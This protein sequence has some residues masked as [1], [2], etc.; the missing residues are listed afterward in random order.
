MRG[1]KRWFAIESKSFEVSVEEARGKIRG[2]IVE[3]SRAKVWE[4]EGRKFK[5]ERRENGT[6]R[7]I[8]CYVIDVESKRFCLMV[9][10][11]KGIPGGWALFAE[12]LRDLGV[13][14]Q[15]EV[16]EKEASRGAEWK[17]R[18][19]FVASSWRESIKEQGEGIGQ[20]PCR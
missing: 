20:V 16:K 2:T 9:P 14:T 19:C 3:R 12:K 1:G 18:R 11:G 10:E 7:Y 6:G 8:L 4:E 5:V 17:A 15:K 13:A